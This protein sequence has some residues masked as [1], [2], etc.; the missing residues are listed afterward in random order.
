L[1]YCQSVDYTRS[2]YRQ[3]T[4]LVDLASDSACLEQQC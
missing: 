2:S 3:H 1:A 4:A